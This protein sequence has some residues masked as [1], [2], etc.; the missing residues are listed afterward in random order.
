[1]LFTYKDAQY[2]YFTGIIMQGCIKKHFFFFFL[3]ELF[4][5]DSES[6]PK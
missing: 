4:R 6:D 1:M 2:F 5:R 3:V